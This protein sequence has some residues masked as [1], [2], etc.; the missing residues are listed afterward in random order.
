MDP[1]NASQ[2]GCLSVWMKW[3]CLHFHLFSNIQ[4][5]TFNPFP[6][7]S[8]THINSQLREEGLV[9]S[10]THMNLVTWSG[11]QKSLK[12]Y[13]SFDEMIKNKDFQ[14]NI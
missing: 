13:A 14:N 6:P 9:W 11:P 1:D 10:N 8:I 2:K 5:L 12:F 3:T 7:H 4:A